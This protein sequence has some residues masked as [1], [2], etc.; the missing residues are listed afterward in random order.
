MVMTVADQVVR[1]QGGQ[2]L[3]QSGVVYQGDAPAAQFQISVSTVQSNVAVLLGDP[4]HLKLVSIIVPKDDVDRPG[5]SL[6]N[7]LQSKRRAKVA[8]KEQGLTILH[9][10]QR[11]PQFL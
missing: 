9:L 5:E 10:V 7:L 8:A 2:T 4:S 1:S 6:G 3:G 11:L